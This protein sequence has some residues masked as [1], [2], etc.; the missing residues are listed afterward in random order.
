MKDAIQTLIIGA[1][2]VGALYL[3]NRGAKGVASDTAE[4]V[5]DVASGATQGAL[6]GVLGVPYTSEDKCAKAMRECNS[7]DA[8]FY[9]DVG[10][11]LK[12]MATPCPK[13][14]IIEPL[15]PSMGRGASGS[16]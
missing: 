1:G 12:Y 9:C 3:F 15:E 5:G 10:T 7:W 13:T 16:W 14:Q 2:V 6:H 8:S 4:V 11:Y